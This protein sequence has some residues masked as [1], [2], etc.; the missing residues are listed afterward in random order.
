MKLQKH[1]MIPL[2]HDCL[3]LGVCFSPSPS[4]PYYLSPSPFICAISAP[5]HPYL[6]TSAP[7]P[8]FVLSQPLPLPY[9]GI[10]SSFPDV[11]CWISPSL[12][13]TA[14]T[15]MVG[16]IILEGISISCLA[17]F[18]ADAV[19]APFDH[20]SSCAMELQE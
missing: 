8:S 13:V 11:V 18:C 12:L 19:T 4:L 10:I 3:Y 17:K 16:V 20:A 9:L 14:S 15:N 6:T 7:P 1:N 5:P 2:I